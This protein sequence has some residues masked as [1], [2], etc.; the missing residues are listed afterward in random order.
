MERKKKLH[1]NRLMKANNLPP[2]TFEQAARPKRKQI[3][4][5][6][7][8]NQ[9]EDDSSSSDDSDDNWLILDRQPV[10][11]PVPVPEVVSPVPVPP[12]APPVLVPEVVPL[13]PA[14]P[15]EDLI[16]FDENVV[17]ENPKIG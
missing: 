8:D 17:E 3:P 15:V 6:K 4:V 14:P 9:V 13:V 16:R 10:L 2:D 11:Q 7:P 1:R 5:R 12:V